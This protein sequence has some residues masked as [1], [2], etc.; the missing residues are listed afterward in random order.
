MCELACSV[1]HSVRWVAQSLSHSLTTHLLT[2]SLTHSP[3]LQDLSCEMIFGQAPPPL[4][5]D[6]VYKQPCFVPQ[7][8]LAQ[9]LEACPKTDTERAA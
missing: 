3:T 6:P 8:S 9:K 1:T 5:E 4:E 2:H 7:C